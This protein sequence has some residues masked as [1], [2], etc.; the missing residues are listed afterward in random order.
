MLCESESQ[1]TFSSASIV[2]RKI[3]KNLCE[4]EGCLIEHI[5]NRLIL[6]LPERP[7]NREVFKT[8]DCTRHN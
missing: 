7:T 8:L 4:F 6:C 1:L 2:N 5:E 3:R